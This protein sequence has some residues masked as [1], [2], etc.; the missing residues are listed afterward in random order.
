MLSTPYIDILHVNVCKSKSLNVHE[1]VTWAIFKNTNLIRFVIIKT[2]LNAIRGWLLVFFIKIV[3]IWWPIVQPNTHINSTNKL[4]KHGSQSFSEERL[5]L[6][7]L[8]GMSMKLNM[9]IYILK[10]WTHLCAS[11]YFL[12]LSSKPWKVARKHPL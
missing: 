2:D 9:F 10:M 1:F 8:I 12:L 3:P 7:V 6:N 11:I 4:L 5:V